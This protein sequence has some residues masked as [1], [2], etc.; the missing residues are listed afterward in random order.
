MYEPTIEEPYKI[1]LQNIRYYSQ[2]TYSGIELLLV[3]SGEI[4]VLVNQ[5]SIHLSENDLLLINANHVRTIKGNKE[6]VV[7]LLQIPLSLIEQHYSKI[8]EC[9]FD[10]NSTKKDN[11]FYL[12]FD[13]IRQLLAEILIAQYQKQEGNELEINSLIYK[14]VTLLIRNFKSTYIGQ[15]QIIGMK[16]ERIRNI[17]AFIEKNY[18]KSI[19]LED[20]AKQQYLSLYYLSRFFKQEVGISFTQYVKQVRLKSAVHELLNTN[21]SIIQVAL[22]NGFPNAKSF[23]KVFKE[24]YQQ[25]PAEYR[26]LHKKEPSNGGEGFSERD[27]Y[28]LLK[29]PKFLIEISKY[30]SSSNNN[31]ITMVEPA[32]STVYIDMPKEPIFTRKK[33]SKLLVIGQLEY[34]LHEEVQAQLQI[35]Q[36]LL[37]FEYIYFSNLFSSTL[38]ITT[39]LFQTGGKFYQI[40]ALFTRMRQLGLVPFIRVEFEKEVEISSEYLKLLDEFLQH[41]IQYF[42]NAFVGQWQF[43]VVFTRWDETSRAFYR[44]FYQA[45]KK[46]SAD[47]KVGL[48]VPYRLERGING[49]ATAFLKEFATVCDLICFTCNPNEHVDFT[50]MNNSSF[51]GVKSFLKKSCIDLKEQLK[52]VGLVDSSIYLTNWNTLYGNTVD[53]SGSF[54][55]SSLIF[56]D[57][58][59]VMREISGVGFWIDT[60]SLEKSNQEYEQIAMNGIALFYYYQLKRPAFF[61]IQLMAKLSPQ[62]LAEGDDFVLTK[63]EGGY[64]LAIY[65]TSYVN[66]SYSVESFFLRSLTKETR[67]VISGLSPGHYQIR[68]HILDRNNGAFYMN[69]INFQRGN[70]NDGETIAFLKQRT[71]PELQIYE[72]EIA[73]NLYLQTTLTL[74]AFHLFE[75][76]PLS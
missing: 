65:N 38:T 11:G 25:T 69:W 31:L 59:D 28:T 45:V 13:Q 68:K 76:K 42:G 7:A 10:C 17:L 71:F 41:S 6:N 14:L 16:N 19:S 26:S 18:R 8:H 74:N 33:S 37:H 2:Y 67:F 60:H 23:N 56:K 61:N 32:A 15:N 47:S 48:H 27:Q 39:P 35:I 70:I 36:E 75:I 64:Q 40:N 72:E 58:F 1:S 52:S 44:D 62:I 22:N 29:S 53:L 24:M 30:I 9:Y 51:E 66:P 49:Q 12:L 34:A 50:D 43:E 57:M 63:G 3:I 46:W 55:R 73:S 21:N 5:Q 4:E 54:F 20:I